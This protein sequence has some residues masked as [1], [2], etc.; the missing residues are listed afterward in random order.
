MAHVV[1]LGAGIGGV[2][3][4]IEV[5]D[6]LAKAHQVTVVSD[7][8]NFQFTP[9][10][11]WL[12]VNWR[13]PEELK[14]PLAPVFRKKNIGFTDVGAKT[15]HPKENRVELNNGESLSY[16]YLVIAT[17]PKLAF[18]EI[19]GL[20]PHG[21]HTHS[22]C[23]LQ[24]AEIASTAW[25]EFCKDPGPIVIGAA[26]AVSC[27]GPAYEYAMIVSTD[28]R[29]RGIR[30]KV[31]MTFVTAEPY[32]G[33]LGLGGV[34]DTKGMLESA[35]RDRD[36]KWITNAKTTAVEPGLLK[37]DE[38]NDDGSLK[39]S[40]EI[41]FKFGMMMPAFTGIDALM[42]VE[43]LVNPRGFV[44]IDKNQRNPTYPNVFGVGVCVAIPPA[45][46]TPV[47]TGMPKTGYMIESMVTAT[48]HNIAALINGKEAKEEG[49]WNAVCLADFGDRG[50][51]FVAQPQI[52][53][54]NVN[55]SSEGRWVHLAKIAYE[56]YFLRK[57][58]K[59]QSEPV[60]ERYI[61]KLLGIKRLRDAL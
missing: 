54:R 57:V 42:G 7:I 53:P 30:H 22:I 13:K 56:K 45:E 32:I 31:P 55:W 48:A 47:A 44:L 14:V 6:E 46:P 19:P 60:Y 41:P 59:G 26:P 52:P 38:L 3:A 2:A 25:E 51:A 40:H 33:H 27:F 43:G 10:N 17:G 9:S 35:F 37:C 28:L 24:H 1:I 18:G 39:K 49:T 5:R 36:I 8:P 15:V 11:P 29:R 50:V 61:M 23:T 16:D 20:G 21:G 12:A 58:R 4:A 34:G